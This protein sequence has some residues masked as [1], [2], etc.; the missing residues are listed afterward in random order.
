M[1]CDYKILAEHEL[2]SFRFHGKLSMQDMLS[3]TDRVDTDPEYLPHYDEI[4]DF[5]DMTSL[6]IS[7]KGVWA[8]SDMILSLYI[9]SGRMKR[10]ALV[11]NSGKGRMIC[12]IFKS[13]MSRTSTLEVDYFPDHETALDFLG[14]DPTVLTKVRLRPQPRVLFE[15]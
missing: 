15:N 9:R 12:R 2:V 6:S 1:P 13:V 7:P 4:G 3:A 14:R 10:I 5:T 8:L 11:A